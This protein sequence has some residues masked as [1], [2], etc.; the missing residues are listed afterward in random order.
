MNKGP[1]RDPCVHRVTLKTAQLPPLGGNW[2]PTCPMWL[3]ELTGP[4]KTRRLVYRDSRTRVLTHLC[5]YGVS[6]PELG[7]N[8]CTYG[9]RR[10]RVLTH[11]RFFF[12]QILP[13]PLTFR[14]MRGEV[15]H[16]GTPLGRPWP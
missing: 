1:A 10:T 4:D 6:R 14:P 12:D 3:S 8:W 5:W 9:T 13:A 2:E 11:L 15:S 16:G 7:P